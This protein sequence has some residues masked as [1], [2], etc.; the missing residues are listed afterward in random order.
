MVALFLDHFRFPNH[1][2]S[3]FPAADMETVL[4]QILNA[5]LWSPHTP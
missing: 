4:A 3:A 5:D 1:K 2:G